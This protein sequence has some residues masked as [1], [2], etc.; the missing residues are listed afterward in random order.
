MHPVNAPLPELTFIKVIL[1]YT[2][3]DKDIS[4][5]AIKKFCGICPQNY[6]HLLFLMF[7]SIRREQW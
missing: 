6:A 2:E 7:R 3:I 4:Q 5:I 1:N